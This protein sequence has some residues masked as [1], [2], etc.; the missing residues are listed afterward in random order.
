MPGFDDDS[1]W[2]KDENE[3]W[4]RYHQRQTANRRS[5]FWILIIAAVVILQFLFASSGGQ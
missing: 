4:D 5:F 2:L 1:R 3:F